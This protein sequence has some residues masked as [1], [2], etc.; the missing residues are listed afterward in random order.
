[1]TIGIQILLGR[2]SEGCPSLL[3]VSGPDILREL[4]PLP[5]KK[6]LREEWGLAELG[7]FVGQENQGQK[8]PFTFA[9]WIYT[10]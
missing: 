2:H 4:W 7:V 10:G 3:L 6:A 5:R 9:S 8:Y 1:M